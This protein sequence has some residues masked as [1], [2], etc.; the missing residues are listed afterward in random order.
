MVRTVWRPPT[1]FH[2]LDEDW[3]SSRV[4]ALAYVVGVL[5]KGDGSVFPSKS[6]RK[7]KS[8]VAT[9]RSFAIQLQ[10]VSREFALRFN[11]ECSRVL[12]RP[13]VKVQGPRNGMLFVTYHSRDFGQWWKSQ[14]LSSLTRFID[15][16]TVA[17]LRGRF[18]SDGNVSSYKVYLCGAE[19]HRDV[20]SFD[21]GLCARLGMRTGP[22]LVY[23]KKGDVTKIRDRVVV[24]TMDRIRF[25]V[26]S[27]DFLHTIGG[28][29]VTTRDNALHR[30][31]GRPWTPWPEEVRS[32]ALALLRSGHDFQTTS[33]LLSNDLGVRVPPITV[34]FWSRRGTKSWQRFARQVLRRARKQAATS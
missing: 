16:H 30:R 3:P 18:D 26:N 31:A 14:K 13:A 24:R 23:G 11:S 9:Y 34:Y 15:L 19:N 5:L 27:L 17:Y 2:G 7:K 1:S 28:F 25:S 4:S 21:R 8:G 12:G 20:M 22:V 32:R 33:R 6:F 29:A 10:V